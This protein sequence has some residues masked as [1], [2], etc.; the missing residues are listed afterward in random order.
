MNG[1]YETMFAILAIGA[2]VLLL[3][4]KGRTTSVL[5]LRSSGWLSS[6]GQPRQRAA[7]ELVISLPER[8]EFVNVARKNERQVTDFIERAA[9]GI[10]RVGLDGIL[11]EV[12]QKF[13][14]MLGYD[15]SELIGK[16]AKDI[17]H[18][19]DCDQGPTLR[20]LRTGSNTKS[21]S[22]EK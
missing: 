17:N 2:L 7:T 8:S 21:A 5:D 14:D 13:C 3:L 15:R 10:C 19:E 22:G 12:N 18:P 16:A 11:L 1:I 9:V 4:L 6:A 20:T